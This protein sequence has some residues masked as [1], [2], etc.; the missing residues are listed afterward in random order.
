MNLDGS[1][2]L[3]PAYDLTYSSGPG[4]EHWTSYLGE[5]SN[6]PSS[7]LLSLAQIGSINRKTATDIIEKVRNAVDHFPALCKDLRIPSHY[8]SPI[9]REMQAR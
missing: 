3:S 7:T 6:V 5:G 2:K 9:I 8:S 1:W 4:G